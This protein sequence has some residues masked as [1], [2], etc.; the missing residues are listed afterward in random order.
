M[1]DARQP[2]AFPAFHSPS[3]SLFTAFFQRP[4]TI[5]KQRLSFSMDTCMC[6]CIC[7]WICVCV[8]VSVSLP[9]QR[10][11]QI[12]GE[13]TCVYIYLYIYIHACTDTHTHAHIHMCINSDPGLH[14]IR[15]AQGLCQQVCLFWFVSS[16]RAWSTSAFIRMGSSVPCS[17]QCCRMFS[18]ILWFDNLMEKISCF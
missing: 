17:P 4:L 15:I 7:V 11:R 5:P 10:V 8:Y 3:V 6:V 2:L 1:L 9:Q 18:L 12:E 14:T 13:K 16:L